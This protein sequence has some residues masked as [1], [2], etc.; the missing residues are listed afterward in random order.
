MDSELVSILA[1]IFSYIIAGWAFE[2][3]FAM[4]QGIHGFMTTEDT[5]NLKNILLKFQAIC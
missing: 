5:L 4:E 1:S 3:H 2:Y